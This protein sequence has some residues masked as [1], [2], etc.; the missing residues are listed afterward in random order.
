[1]LGEL[2]HIFLKDVRKNYEHDWG[3]MILSSDIEKR[4][5][6]SVPK[7]LK[8]IRHNDCTR[9]VSH[10]LMSKFTKGKYK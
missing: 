8:N 3:K 9:H 1:M 7:V 2:E 4:F 5:K 10:N 6:K